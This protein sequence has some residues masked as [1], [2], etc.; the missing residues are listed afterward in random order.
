MGKNKLSFS[1]IKRDTYS[2]VNSYEKKSKKY[3]KYGTNNKFP[4]YIIGLYSNSSIHASCVN[5]IVEAVKGEGLVTDNEFILERANSSGESWNDIYNK[6][7]LD[8]KLF[9]GFS[10]EIIWSQDRERIAEVYHIDFS[11]LRATEKTYRGEIPA[12]YIYNDWAKHGGFNVDID[13][14]PCLP[15]YN[16]SKKQEEPKQ[17]FVHQPY[18]PGKEY[19]PLPDYVAA[20]RVIDLDQEVD[21][22]H[23]NNIKN[24]LTPSLSVTT[25]TNASDDE[26]M[27]IERMLKEQYSGTNNAGS[28]MYID[29]DDPANAPVITPIPQNGA[30]GYYVAINDMVSQKILTAHRITSPAL[31][32]IKENTG[33]GNNAEELETA[34]RLFLNTVVLPYQQSIL[35]CFEMILGYNHDDITLGVIQKNPL[36]ESDDDGETEVVTSQESDVNDVIEIEEQVE[37]INEQGND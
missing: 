24:G 30:D 27:A 35:S 12:Y 6:V 9:G 16:P 11:Y 2:S 28:L 29:V 4:D 17:I 36:Y 25:F 22:F 31:L 18:S 23:I 13:D 14:M 21:N 10:L 19:Y 34:Y 15:V 26:R 37:E 3:I 33:L 20:A 1:N 7:A 8:Y 5:A 32:G